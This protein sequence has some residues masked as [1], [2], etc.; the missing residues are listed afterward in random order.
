[1]EVSSLKSLSIK[2]EKGTFYVPD[3]YF[4]AESGHCLIEGESYLE[5]TWTFFGDLLNWL[6]VFTETK[7]PI[8]F[9][10]KLSYFNTSSSKGILQLLEFLQTYEEEGGQVT[11]NWYYPEHDEDLREEAEDFM[12]DT[13]LNINLLSF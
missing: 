9:D 11:V 4:N 7:K 8:V 5:N 12:I 10:F 6:K 2:G 3:V 13:N 1:M